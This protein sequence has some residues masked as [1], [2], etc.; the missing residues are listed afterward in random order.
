[1]ESENNE[2]PVYNWQEL[3]EVVRKWAVMTQFQQILDDYEQN[4][5][6]SDYN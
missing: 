2:K 3:D 6:D 1:M 5:R 4:K